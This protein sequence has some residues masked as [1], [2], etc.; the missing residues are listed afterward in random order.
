MVCQKHFA[1]ITFNNKELCIEEALSR[2]NQPLRIKCKKTKI[3]EGN[4]ANI[5]HYG[6]N[7]KSINTV[8]LL[9]H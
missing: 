3:A 4:R 7:V 5:S 2:L 1:T 9:E 8:K 6:L